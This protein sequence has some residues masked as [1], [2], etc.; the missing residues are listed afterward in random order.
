M[1]KLSLSQKW[2][3]GLVLEYPCHYIKSF[4][5]LRKHLIKFNRSDFKA[6]TINWLNPLSLNMKCR[7]KGTF[8]T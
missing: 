1:S 3:C 5:R 6:R 4:N 7:T 2:K 8:F